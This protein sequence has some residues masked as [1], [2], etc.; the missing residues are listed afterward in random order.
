M[1]QI[2]ENVKKLIC[3]PTGPKFG[4]PIFFFKNLA[5]SVTRYQ[6]QLQKC[7]ISEKTNY[8]VLRK[9]SDRWT[10][11][12]TDGRTDRQMDESDLKGRCPTNDERSKIF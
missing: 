8:P 4:P 2:Q 9:F 1:I 7:A 12:Q 6:G 10:N 5:P 11:T 3:R